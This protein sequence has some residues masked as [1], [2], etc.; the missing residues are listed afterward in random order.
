MKRPT[1]AECLGVSTRWQALSVLAMHIESAGLISVAG[2]CLGAAVAVHCHDT[3]R[4]RLDAHWM[5]V[6]ARRWQS[7][8]R[9]SQDARNNAYALGLIA[10]ELL[11]ELRERRARTRWEAD[12]VP[13]NCCGRCDRC[14]SRMLGH[15]MDPRAYVTMCRPGECYGGVAPLRTSC[16]GCGKRLA[17]VKT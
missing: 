6:A 1:L 10:W 12:V 9:V 5:C 2:D 14:G 3:E 11:A 17:E 16:A 4:L 7:P 8:V 15:G 13:R